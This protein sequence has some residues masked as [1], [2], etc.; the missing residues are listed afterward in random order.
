MP[1][2]RWEPSERDAT[3]LRRVVDGTQT[4]EGAAREIQHDPKTIRRY[5]RA[6]GLV[7]GTVRR[8]AGDAAEPEDST[9]EYQ[10]ETPAGPVPN[11]WDIAPQSLDSGMWAALEAVQREMHALDTEVFEASVTLPDDGPVLVV[12]LSDLH[13]GHVNCDMPRLRRDLELVRNTPGVYAVLLGDLID[14]VVTAV[15][16]RGMSHEQLAPIRVQK[17][18]V[19]DAVEFLGAGNVLGMVL[20]NHD[21]F[22]I[23]SDDYDPVAYW[24]KKTGCPYLGPFGF[25]NVTVGAETYR[26]LASHMFRMRSSFNLTHQAKRLEDFQGAADAVFTGHTHESAAESTYRQHRHKFYGQCGSYLSTTRYS[27]SLGFGQVNADMPGVILWPDRHK[28]LGFQ[29]A[30]TDG[31]PYLTYLRGASCPASS[32]DPTSS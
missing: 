3:V 1:F 25:L 11:R 17:A 18:L 5:M 28:V 26:I 23:R 10:A 19:D 6:H 22:S 7:P 31:V 32:T 30:L 2:P 16:S 4:L 15:T 14:N 24:A 29:D 20:G 9:P 12:V 27:K 13:V 8:M 21:A